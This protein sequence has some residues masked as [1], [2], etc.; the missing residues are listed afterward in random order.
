MSDPQSADQTHWT[1]VKLWGYLREEESIFFG[2]DSKEN[3]DKKY[4]SNW[5]DYYR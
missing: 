5:H 3:F 4:N 1:G 2:Y